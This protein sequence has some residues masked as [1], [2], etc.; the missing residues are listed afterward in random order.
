VTFKRDAA[1]NRIVPTQ[2]NSI[3]APTLCAVLREAEAE[4][5]KNADAAAAGGKKVFEKL[6][7]IVELLAAVDAATG[8]GAVPRAAGAGAAA[9]ASE[10]TVT[11]KFLE[12][13]AKKLPGQI[14]EGGVA[15]GDIEVAL[16]GTELAVRRSLMQNV[17]RIP[18]GKALQ[19]VW[20]TAAI[21]AGRQAGAKTVVIAMRTVQNP[22]WAAYLESQGYTW[23]VLNKLFGQFGVEKALVKTVTL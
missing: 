10:A 1:S 15:S 3:T 20:E 12:L 19:S 22:T 7:V 16:E 14:T 2:V 9:T 17:S 4:Y 18:A 21:A 8:A 13:L 5:V 23:Q 6:K 11:R